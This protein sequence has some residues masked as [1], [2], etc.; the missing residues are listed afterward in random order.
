MIDESFSYQLKTIHATQL[1]RVLHKVDLIC[2]VALYRN[3]SNPFR[4]KSTI[5]R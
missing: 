5:F 4:L 1:F 3:N 2:G